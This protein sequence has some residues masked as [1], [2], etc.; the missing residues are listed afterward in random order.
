[1]IGVNIDVTHRKQAEEVLREKE[2]LLSESQRI[3]HIGSWMRNLADSEE[4]LVWSDELYR[5]YG[6]D[7]ES[8]VPTIECLIQKIFPD[9]QAALR[10]WLSTSLTTSEVEA[11]RAIR[12]P[13]SMFR[14]G[15]PLALMPFT[16]LK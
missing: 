10:N 13:F 4:R 6:V 3:A 11:V 8:F 2:H 15:E 14:R 12:G 5:M 1:M 7:K 16:F 9:D